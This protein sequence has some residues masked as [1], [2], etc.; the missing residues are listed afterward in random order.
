MLI[1]KQYIKM[2]THGVNAE[3]TWIVKSYT[4]A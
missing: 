2:V 1:I 3:V 4:R